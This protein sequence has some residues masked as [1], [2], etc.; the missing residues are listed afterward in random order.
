MLKISG[1]YALSDFRLKKL[2][3]QLQELSPV[4]SAVSAQFIHFVDI[5]GELDEKETGI[6]SQLLAYGEVQVKAN[7]A[8]DSILVVP[9]SGTISPW[10]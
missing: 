7:D 5:D 1:T 9:R 10:S 8:Q 4:V 2:L 6:L 3:T